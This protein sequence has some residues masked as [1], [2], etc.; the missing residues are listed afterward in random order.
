MEAN[1][2]SL[3]NSSTTGPSKANREE[4]ADFISIIEP[5][6]TPVTSAIS[7]GSTKSVFTEWLCDSLSPAKV[8]STAEGHDSTTWFNKAED[9]A[10]LGNYINISKREFGVSD[11]QQLVDQAGLDSE[12]DNAKSKSVRE[13]KRD[14]EGVVCGVQDRASTTGNYASRGLFDW[15]D[16]GGPADVP[17]A[18]RPPAGSISDGVAA[19]GDTDLTEAQLNTVLQ[20]MFT[21]SGEKKSYMGVM[22]PIV[23]DI[24]D[25]FTRV[26]S[27]TRGR[28]H[29]NEPSGSKTIN[30]EVKTFNSSFGVINMIPSVFLGGSNSGAELGTAG[31]DDTLAF[32]YDD[33]AGLI[34]DTDSLELKFLDSM[35][36]ESFEDRGGGPRGHA[37]AVYTLV[38]KNP[39]VHG[40][41]LAADNHGS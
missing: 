7:K 13:L 10:R 20:S 38:V 8:D 27:S 23:I 41:I 5:E 35:H 40:K 4:L 32:T 18:Y 26:D 17:A 14:I 36:T 39:K 21:V 22:S 31:T 33:D 12:I 2:Y 29:V 15:I 24:I 25:N 28:Y 3:Y 9:R 1:T 6:V 16:S 11:V 19:A 34:L 30:L 37:K